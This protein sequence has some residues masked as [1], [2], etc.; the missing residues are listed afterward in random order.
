MELTRAIAIGVIAA[1]FGLAAAVKAQSLRNV[2]TPNEFPPAFYKGK[3]YV[4]SK[5]CVY[6]R[7]GV[8]GNVTWV[9]RMTRD[10]KVICGYKPTNP[11]AAPS[12][13]SAAKLDKNVVVIEPAAPPSTSAL[14]KVLK[15]AS[16]PK[17]T[18]ATTATAAP[19]PPAAK[20]KPKPTT[21]ASAAAPAPAPAAKEG[22]T[23][24][25]DQITSGTSTKSTSAPAATATASTVAPTPKPK[26]KPAPATVSPPPPKKAPTTATTTTTVVAPVATAKTSTQRRSLDQTPRQSGYDAPC[27][28]GVATSGVRCGPQSE[29]PYTPGTGK[30]TAEPPRIIY[31]RQGAA[32]YQP[33][34]PPVGTVVREGEVASN[35][36]VIPRH[37]YENYQFA[38]TKTR[39]PDGFV[40]VFDDGRLNP[41][42]AVMTFAGKAATDAVWQETVP[43]RLQPASEGSAVLSS[44]S[45]PAPVAPVV[46]TKSAPETKALRLSGQ[47]YVQVATYSSADAAQA[48]ARKVRGLGVPVKIGKYERNGSTYRMV[49]AG[50]FAGE[51]EAD[52]A[53]A[54]VRKVGFSGAFVRN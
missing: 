27:R 41:H 3:Q 26:P 32:L 47:S 42:R 2:D 13:T 33:A 10:R 52:R 46:S 24:W 43:R 53:A 36:R 54:A 7:A 23:Y 16:P 25:W 22:G 17:S 48:S 9:P 49:L 50:P 11:N 20:P 39:V 6:I 29:L 45:T 21:T 8:D 37:L 34:T 44:K 12:T 35:V 18:T 40:R 38:Q 4:D 14:D 28:E 5:G 1:S 31:N 30:P 19:K 15:P 51:S